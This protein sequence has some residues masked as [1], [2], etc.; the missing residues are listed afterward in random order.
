MQPDHRQPIT[1]IGRSDQ[2]VGHTD[3]QIAIAAPTTELVLHPV[4]NL[5]FRYWSSIAIAFGQLFL[6]LTLGTTVGF[7]QQGFHGEA[8]PVQVVRLIA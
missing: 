1:L 3:R 5:I 6:D 8:T 2:R 7:R 4:H